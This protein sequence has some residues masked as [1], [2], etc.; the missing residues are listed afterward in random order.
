MFSPKKSKIL[1]LFG[2]LRKSDS[3]SFLKEKNPYP[4]CKIYEGVCSCKENCMGEIKQNVITRWNEYENT[5]KNSEPE[6]SC[7]QPDHVFL[8]ESS[9]VFT[10]EY[11][12]KEK[13]SRILYTI[14]I[15][16]FIFSS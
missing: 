1:E 7:Q 12:K 10:Y 6:H 16:C 2:K 5:N 4:A 11:L 15:F 8:V 13:P 14:F 9:D 3:F